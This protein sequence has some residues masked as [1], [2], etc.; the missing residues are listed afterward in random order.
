VNNPYLVCSDRELRALPNQWLLAERWNKAGSL[1]DDLK[2]LEAKVERLGIDRLLQD[3]TSALRLLPKEDSWYE[4]LKKTNRVLDRQAHYLRG[5]DVQAQPAFFLQQLSNESFQLDMSELQVHAE[6]ELSERC[7][8]YLR[9][10]FNA[11]LESPEL[12][13][14][15]VGVSG[16]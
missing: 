8:P 14:T 4:K 1:L 16:N 12:I 3:Y 7:L 6:V 5:R 10:K 11:G 13:R 15:L 9:R 2:F